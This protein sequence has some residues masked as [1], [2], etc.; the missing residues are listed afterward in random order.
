MDYTFYVP[1]DTNIVNKIIDLE[2]R[3]DIDLDITTAL[4]SPSTNYNGTTKILIVSF[5]SALSEKEAIVL[6]RL[7][8]VNILGMVPGIDIQA[9][10]TN[11]LPRES[12]V[13][14]AP[15]TAAHDISSYYVV[16]SRIINTSTNQVWTCTDNTK[17]SAAWSL[18]PA[19]IG[20]GKDI[21][22]EQIRFQSGSGTSWRPY[23]EC[24]KTFTSGNPQSCGFFMFSGTTTQG[25]E[26][27]ALRILHNGLYKGGDTNYTVIIKLEDRT[28]TTTVWSTTIISN[29]GATNTN[30][31]L[32]QIHN[33][34]IPANSYPSST[35]LLELTIETT[36]GD[37]A[38]IYIV[39][40]K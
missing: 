32:P 21:G 13:T 24:S 19:D 22:E 28:N 40:I 6:S 36:N 12:Y 29:P 11:S 26:P 14:S 8:D 9:K 35:A 25:G 18:L 2:T 20:F 34:V 39:A 38:R 7:V 4:S 23:I 3:I 10:F 33:Y 30:W 1:D 5:D 16:G 31:P 15:P 27:T 17:N 37:Y